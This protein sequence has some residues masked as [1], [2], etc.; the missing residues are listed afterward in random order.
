MNLAIAEALYDQCRTHGL[1]AR[2]TTCRSPDLRLRRDRDVFRQRLAGV[3]V[4]LRL[5]LL[6]RLAR[7]GIELV[8]GAAGVRQPLGNGH[9]FLERLGF[10]LVQALLEAADR[11]AATLADL[12]EALP[13]NEQ[14]GRAD[15][16]PFAAHRHAPGE[17]VNHLLCRE[18]DHRGL[19]SPRAC[20]GLCRARAR[21]RENL[22]ADA[23]RTPFTAAHAS[24]DDL[25]RRS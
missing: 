16:E 5:R 15:D 11:R 17:R 13:E 12:G 14:A 9:L 1:E 19:L 23:T 22:A 7:V 24:R 25:A 3:R 4:E 20:V 6:D 10:G 8:L 2:V 21:V 18:G